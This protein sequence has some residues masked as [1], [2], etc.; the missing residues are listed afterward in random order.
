MIK[1]TGHYMVD[2]IPFESKIQACIFASRHNKEV[3]WD[4]NNNAFNAYNWTIE[5]DMS[6]DALYDK[7][8]RELR[9]KYDYIILSYSAGA[10]S[11]NILMSFIRQNL[12]IDEIIVNVM[13]KVTENFRVIDT[14]QTAS[15]NAA[16]EHDLQTVPR[17]KEIATIIPNT[18]ITVLDMSNFIFDMFLEY[19][20]ASWVETR[21]EGLNPY[22]VTRYNYAYFKEVR[23][24]FDK[25]KSIGL[26]FGSDKPRTFINKDNNFFIMFNDRAA[27]LIS[28]ADNSQEYT[29]CEIELFYWSPDA[30][31]LLCKQ[32]HVIKRWV[33]FNPDKKDSW[34]NFSGEKFRLVHERLLR[35][36]LY[37]TWNDSWWQA[38]KSVKEWDSEFDYFFTR[39]HKDSKSFQIW[40][41]GI[42]YV[43]KEASKYVRYVDGVPDGLN[44]F[45]N[46]YKIGKVN[47][48]AG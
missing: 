10:D 2:N 33:E 12:H 16:A 5:P 9:E 4:F 35:S 45:A 34:I 8:S 7:R 42:N 29:N 47:F 25:N 36:I 14:R 38:D 28:V 40:K 17:L 3:I 39:K 6:L 31:D 19:N 37:S 24:K 48:H 30:L 44:I 43:T 18:K 21:T 26:V 27:N 46:Y 23:N 20:D 15:W 41:E 13:D 1:N 32:A 22:N 11:H